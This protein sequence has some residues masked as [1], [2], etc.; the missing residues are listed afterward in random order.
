VNHRTE[1]GDAT[2][3]SG[4]LVYQRN[5]YYWEYNGRPVLLLGGS[6]EDN[7]FQVPDIDK[8]LDIL[9]Q[10]GGNYVRNTMS[11]RD[12]GNVWPFQKVGEKYDLDR[13]DPEYWQR[14]SRFLEQTAERDVIVQIEIWA[15]FDFYRDYWKN[16]N[17]FNPRNNLNYTAT[18]T[19]LRETVDSHPVK[20]GNSF[21][22]S[23]PGENNQTTL[24]RYQQKFVDK[25]LSY[26]LQ[27]NHVLYCMDN[28]TSVTPEWG[29][30]WSRY[31]KE[32]ARAKGKQV[33]TTEMWDNW[34]LGHA[35]HDAT[36]DHP[37]IYD[38]VDASQNNHNSGQE[39]YY[40]II[41]L[42]KRISQSK[43]P[44]N[45]VKIYGGHGRFGSE[46]DGVDRFWRNIF[47]GAA[48]ARFHR[49]DSGIG[50]SDLA[51]R[52]I[53]S[54]REVTAG[55]DIFNCRPG[56]DL[57]R[58]R[59]T[60]EAYLLTDDKGAYFVYFPREGS[61]VID[62]QMQSAVGVKWFDIYEG[63]WID[64]GTCGGQTEIR[65]STPVETGCVALVNPRS[66]GIPQ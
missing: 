7:L 55:F 15:T 1:T 11:S 26:S 34:D 61:V 53:R 42:R 47:A 8:Q 29:A 32:S 24:L 45:N 18:G 38:F 40:N 65:L 60:D 44:I 6:V 3:S 62:T 49:P 13:W 58:Q 33:Y 54:A 36:I 35:Q 66:S 63:I 52:M 28:E 20:T 23:V 25:I 27:Y 19:G 46:K 10:A 16:S 31:I 59:E 51:Q 43:R 57:L 17:P 56:N 39:H 22:W 12:P 41:S 5:P 4:I 50:I 64:G 14:F 30:Y 37:E 21:F 9:V 2:A 48:S